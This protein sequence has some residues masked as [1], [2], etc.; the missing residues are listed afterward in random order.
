MHRAQISKH[1]QERKDKTKACAMFPDH[2][3]IHYVYMYYNKF[4]SYVSLM[5]TLCLV[6]SDHLL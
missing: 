4:V 1:K 2:I 6:K 3:L 5:N